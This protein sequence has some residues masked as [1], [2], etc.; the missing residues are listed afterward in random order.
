MK[1][2][3]TSDTHFGHENIIRYCKR[4]FKSLNEMNK[5]IIHNWNSRVKNEDTI[6]H[7]GDFCFRNSS[8]G[9][10]GE[11]INKNANYWLSKLNGKIIVIKGNHDKSNSL[12]TPIKRIE[13][14][15]GRKMI[16]LI[17]NPNELTK[18]EI[19]QF[20]LILCG[21]VHEIWEIRCNIINVG[22]DVCNFMPISFDEIIKKLN[23]KV[24]NEK[25]NIT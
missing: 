1:I 13:L 25:N 16:L 2:W 18:S 20:D 4:P 24:K 17:H 21:H 19:D 14:E 8:G 15:Y 11:G 12:N 10:K 6:F 23:K 22:V 5:R 9:K 3:F 7:L